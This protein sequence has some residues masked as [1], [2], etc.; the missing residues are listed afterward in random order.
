MEP[1]F[2]PCT[3][4]V[5][6]E[7]EVTPLKVTVLLPTAVRLVDISATLLAAIVTVTSTGLGGALDNDIKVPTCKSLPTVTLP[8]L[9][10]GAVTVATILLFTLAGTS[11]P[12]GCTSTMVVAPAAIGSNAVFWAVPAPPLNTTGLTV[13]APTAGSLLVKS[14][15][16][17][18]PARNSSWLAKFRVVGFRRAERN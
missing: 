5:P 13:S 12:A 2:K 9:I 10:L 6:T 7:V 4:I 15:L 18:C 11:K 8:M 3:Y 16:I 17:D 14:T 1:I